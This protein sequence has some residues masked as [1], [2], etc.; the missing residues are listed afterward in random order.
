MSRNI[1]D[2]HPTLPRSIE[3]IDCTLRDGEQAP[4]VWFTTEEKL[5]L[6]RLLSHA[7]VAVLDAGFPA[8]SEADVE[9]LQEMRHRG[10]QARIGATAR[11]VLSDIVAAEKALAQEVFLFMPTSDLRLRETLGITRERAGE[12][13]R[14][15]AEAVVGRGMTLNLV[16][17]DA[18]R[19]E[20]E[21]LVPMIEQLHR[22]APITRL[23]ICDTVGCAHPAGIEALVRTLDAAFH[24]EIAIC[25]HSHNDFGLAAANT[26]A[27]VAGGARAITCTVNG[28]GERAGNADLAEC[29]A[30]LTH[31][32]GVEHGIDPRALPL[33]SQA[34]ERMSGLHT[35]PTKAVTGF[36]VYR[37]ESGVHVD[38]MLKSARSYEFLPAAWT[39]RRTEYVL[40]KHSGSALIRYLL[41][42]AGLEFDD[43]LVQELLQDVKHD[44]EQRD[45]AEHRRMHALKEAFALLSLSGIDPATVIARTRE[46]RAERALRK[47]GG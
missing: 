29:V 20:P 14:A 46:R 41:S 6:A 24:H 21:Q 1:E 33:L 15:G 13:F 18:T 17:E 39:G 22:H 31:I 35:S 43:E 26:L 10:L 23:V 9:S 8:A 37:H 47:V 30:A 2:F 11:P 32:Y 36:N 34:V 38:G 7:G 5:E 16:C 19:A 40:G 4:G 44:T 3:V 42:E 45:K 12:I 25:T 27:A 28:I